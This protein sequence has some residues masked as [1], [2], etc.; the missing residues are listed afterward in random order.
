EALDLLAASEA[1]ALSRA[2]A[3]AEEDL[4]D[5]DGDGVPD[6]LDNCPREKGPADNHGCPKAKKQLVVLREDRI[7][8]L[9]KVYFAT[10]K[11]RI[12][13]RSNKLL[14]QVAQVLKAHPDLLQ[15]EVQGHTDDQGSAKTNTA[16][17]QAR[18]EAVASYLRRRGV[19]AER[20]AARGYGPLQPLAPNTPPPGPGQ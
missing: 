9:D 1:D 11:A 19:A 12:E 5:T 6:R 13:K 8:I 4:R 15:L 10:G 14:D 3:F 18:A 16:L 2:A 17:S 7:E 20:L